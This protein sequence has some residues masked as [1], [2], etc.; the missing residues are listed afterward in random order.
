L[1]GGIIGKDKFKGVLA[2]DIVLIDM[3]RPSKVID[4]SGKLFA[5]SRGEGVLIFISNV[6]FVQFG[7][8]KSC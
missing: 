7:G 2:G 8:L 1:E 4:F 5:K 3:I 6:T